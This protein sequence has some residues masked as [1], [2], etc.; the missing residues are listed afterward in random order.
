MS[1]SVR[2]ATPLDA[3][4]VFAAEQKY[5]DCPWTSAQIQSEIADPAA[6]FFVAEEDGAFCGYV[7]GVIAADE[8]ELSNIAVETAYRRNGVGYALM[9]ALINCVRSRGAKQ[10]FLLVR[11]DNAAAQKLYDKCGFAVVG[12]R[13]DYYKGSDALIMRLLV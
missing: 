9:N 11:A 13:P 7:S 1:I 2:V 8:C 10:V 4:N 12:K 6:A 3:Q 5:I